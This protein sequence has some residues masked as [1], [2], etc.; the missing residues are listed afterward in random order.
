[1]W[2][3]TLVTG[4]V[5]AVVLALSAISMGTAS[6]AEAASSKGVMKRSAHSFSAPT[7]YSPPVAWIERDT[8]VEVVCFVEGQRAPNSDSMYWY[9]IR[10]DH[11]GSS[12]VHNDNIAAPP[13]TRPCPQT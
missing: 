1:M 4:G 7:V 6:A 12:F 8:P 13:T 5:A 2:R 9:R 10:Q 11:N 3:K